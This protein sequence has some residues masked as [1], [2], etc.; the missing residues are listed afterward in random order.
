MKRRLMKYGLYIV[1]WFLATDTMSQTRK[2]DFP[3]FESKDSS[4][5]LTQFSAIRHGILTGGSLDFL[6]TGQVNASARVFR[7]S[8][9]EPGKF[10]LPVSV[11]T[12][13]SANHFSSAGIDDNNASTLI[14]PGAG[15][16]NIHIDGGE[17]ITGKET[18]TSLH[19]NY[20]FGIRWISLYSQPANRQIT[21]FNLITGAGLTF[22]T[23]AWESDSESSPG[24]FWLNA[25]GLYAYSPVSA[26]K[27][28]FPDAMAHHLLGC[29][30]GMGIELSE[31]L[32]IKLFY[33]HFLNNRQPEAFRRSF[34]QLSFNYS[35]R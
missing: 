4:E 16:L 17:R 13:V 20:Q 26:L 12:G 18:L 15:I 3:G 19:A 1:C 25:R 33:F 31:A 28:L 7:L 9:G 29:S 24:I 23:G 35:T 22:I 21:F 32:D 27:T 10:R 34:L 5:A 8:I 6:Q 2:C 30:G 14:N 11:Y